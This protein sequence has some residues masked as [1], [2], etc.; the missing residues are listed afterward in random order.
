M[1]NRP[2][3]DLSEQELFDLI[4]ESDEGAFSEIY[5]RYKQPLYLHALKM[6]KDRDE[7]KDVIQEV[8]TKLWLKREDLVL[9]TSLLSYLYAT[10]RNKI[11]DAISHEKVIAKYEQSLQIF[12]DKGEFIT[13]NWIRERELTI[14]IDKE[15][16]EL[17]TKMR[18]VFELSRK[19]HLSYAQISKELDVSENTVRK[20]ITKALKKL[21]DKL[22]VIMIIIPLLIE[23]IWIIKYKA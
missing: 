23:M 15:I 19:S 2:Y 11:L 4:Q 16:A 13:D 17:P 8:F 21:R 12:I 1:A 18:V 7:A 3:K 6:L 9:T 22:E 5:Q 14:L 20:H 10:V